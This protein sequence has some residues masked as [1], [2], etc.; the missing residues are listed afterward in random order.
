MKYSFDDGTNSD[1][2][3]ELKIRIALRDPREPLNTSMNPELIFFLQ[4]LKQ[5]GIAGI[6]L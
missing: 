3:E 6:Y 4:I 1:S 5:R 2:T